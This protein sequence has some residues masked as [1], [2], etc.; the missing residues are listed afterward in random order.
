MSNEHFDVL[1]L[2]EDEEMEE[3]CD[4]AQSP[5]HSSQD[6]GATQE[7]LAE[8]QDGAHVAAAVGDQGQAAEQIRPVE[9]GAGSQLSLFPAAGASSQAQAFCEPPAAPA[10]AQ[11][12]DMGQVTTPVTV[13]RTEW[14][15]QRLGATPT[16]DRTCGIGGGTDHDR[17]TQRLEGLPLQESF[18]AASPSQL[19]LHKSQGSAGSRAR[20]PSFKLCDSD[21]DLD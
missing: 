16:P 4:S 11:P 5:E 14:R 2:D 6:E 3:Q 7:D 17:D 19:S 10:A 12:P 8:M 15:E 20:K 18:G 21:S 9:D 13:Q 1:A